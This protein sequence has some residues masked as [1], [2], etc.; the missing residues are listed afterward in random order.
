MVHVLEPNW[1]TVGKYGV[2]WSGR[3]FGWIKVF[4]FE[5]DIVVVIES[6]ILAC[7][8]DFNAKYFVNMQ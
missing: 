6:K 3:E 2:V 1:P 4:M 8:D 5:C 7:F